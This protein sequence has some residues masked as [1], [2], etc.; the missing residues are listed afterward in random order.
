[1]IVRSNASVYFCAMHYDRLNCMGAGLFCRWLRQEA[2]RPGLVLCPLHAMVSH[3]SD[4]VGGTANSKRTVLGSGEQDRRVLGLDRGSFQDRLRP[5]EVPTEDTSGSSGRMAADL[6]HQPEWPATS[7][8]R[9][10][11]V[12][13]A[14]PPPRTQPQVTCR[15]TQT[16]RQRQWTRERNS[17]S[18]GAP[19]RR[20]EHLSRQKRFAALPGVYA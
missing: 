4:P 10:Q 11:S 14:G 3:W 6:R 12:R 18:T 1:M 5:S 16:A 2:L 19:L 7:H 20:R 9:E 15:G 13:S 17:L 8:L